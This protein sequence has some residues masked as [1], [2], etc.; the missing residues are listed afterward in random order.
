MSE[1][2]LAVLAVVC[3]NVAIGAVLYFQPG[4][5]LWRAIRERLVSAFAL[6]RWDSQ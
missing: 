5:A 2:L 3:V 4:E 1:T 6:R